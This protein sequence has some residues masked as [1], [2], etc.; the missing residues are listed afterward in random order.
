MV[1]AIKKIDINWLVDKANTVLFLEA[2]QAN[3]DILI[4]ELLSVSFLNYKVNLTDS[5]IWNTGEAGD[6]N[7]KKKS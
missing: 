6:I 5:T 4:T 3:I 7:E 2:L 1:N